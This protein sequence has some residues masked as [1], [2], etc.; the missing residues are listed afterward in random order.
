MLPKDRH[1]GINNKHSLGR[2]SDVYVN[3]I[4]VPKEENPK[5]AQGENNRMSFWIEGFPEGNEPPPSG[6]V[7]IEM[8]VSA[9]D[10]KYKLRAKTGTPDQIAKY[11]SD[12]LKKVTEEVPPKLDR[13]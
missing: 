8:S 12:F 1:F 10:R 13:R 2:K 9:L 6:K 4:N 7:K 5:G 3:F 11:L